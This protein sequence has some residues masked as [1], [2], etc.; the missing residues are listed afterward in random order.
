MNCEIVLKN[1]VQLHKVFEE[2]NISNRF[3]NLEIENVGEKFPD[4]YQLSILLDELK[5][6]SGKTE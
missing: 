3:E 5:G 4:D 6:D 2:D 1:S